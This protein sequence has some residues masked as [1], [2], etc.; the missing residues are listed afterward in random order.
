[1]WAG[2]RRVQRKL[3][4]VRGQLDLKA[5]FEFIVRL[6]QYLNIALVRE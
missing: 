3:E 5:K 4:R 6:P 1:M 2:N